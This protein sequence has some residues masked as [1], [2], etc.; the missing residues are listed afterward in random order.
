MIQMGMGKEYVINFCR[1]ETESCAI[2]F[3]KLMTALV[4]AAIN[5]YVF[6]GTIDQVTGTGHAAIGAV[7]R[8]VQVAAPLLMIVIVP[9]LIEGAGREKFM[10]DLL[11]T[12]YLIIVSNSYINFRYFY[13]K[14]RI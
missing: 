10:R 13:M 7:K 11:Q 8:N 4:H 1:I 6:A 2:F 5:Q 3:V 12:R 9:N 14:F